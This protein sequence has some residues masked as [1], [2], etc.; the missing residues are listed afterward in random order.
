MKNGPLRP[1]LGGGKKDNQK[2]TQSDPEFWSLQ[3]THNSK[4]K[5]STAN[6]MHK[7]LLQQS[8]KLLS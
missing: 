4:V 8:S 7:A 1:I 6:V 3:F 2:N 5:K